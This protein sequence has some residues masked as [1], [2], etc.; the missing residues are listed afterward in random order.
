MQPDGHLQGRDIFVG[1]QMQRTVFKV[2]LKQSH[3]VRNF[4]LGDMMD[5][6]EISN[7]MSLL[8]GETLYG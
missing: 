1:P 5:N 6:M 8:G 7:G 4:T 2:P 3:P